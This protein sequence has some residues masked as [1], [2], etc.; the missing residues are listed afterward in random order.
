[1]VDGRGSAADPAENL[2]TLLGLSSQ[3]IHPQFWMQ[4]DATE[5]R[6]FISITISS[7]RYF[8]V[9]S[10]TLDCITTFRNH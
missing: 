9:S 2:T 6:S 7:Q 8:T 5:G 10:W 1:M 3:L 4:M